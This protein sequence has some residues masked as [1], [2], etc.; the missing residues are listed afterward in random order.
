MSQEFGRRT[1]PPTD[2]DGTISDMG[3]FY[4][5][6]PN[7]IT[8]KQVDNIFPGMHLKVFPNSF[9]RSISVEFD[10]HLQSKDVIRIYDVCTELIEML[11]DEE[12]DPGNH[13]MEWTGKKYR[14]GIYMPCGH[15]WE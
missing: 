2:P 12:M 3:A 6:T 10:I 15:L 14:P 9:T 1:V 5:G 8:E 7:N 13:R 4:F 11:L